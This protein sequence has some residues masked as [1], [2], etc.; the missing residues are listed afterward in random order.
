MRLRS[1]HTAISDVD[2]NDVVRRRRPMR[3][4]RAF[5]ATVALLAVLAP[6]AHGA[7]TTLLVDQANPNCSNTGTGSVSQPFC[8]ITAANAKVVPG[9]TVQVAAGNYPER[10]SV[11]SGTPDARVVYAAAPGATVTVGVGQANGFIA[12]GK[13]WVTING[14]KITQTTSYGIDVSS[15]AGNVTV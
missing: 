2:Q 11:K 15:G 8:T 12:S 10:I 3:A 7:S 1:P 5:V 6:S 9:T 13:S 14:F 4:K